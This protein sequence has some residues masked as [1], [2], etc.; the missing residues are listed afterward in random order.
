[1]F[2]RRLAST[3]TLIIAVPDV[4]VELA[5]NQVF[6]LSHLQSFSESSLD[7]LGRRFG[8]AARS[9][10]NHKELMFAFR[11]SEGAFSRLDGRRW[12][13]TDAGNATELSG[14]LINRLQTPWLDNPEGTEVT[15]HWADANDW[16][17]RNPTL[18]QK[19]RRP[20]YVV[21]KG[22]MARLFAFGKR[23][24]PGAIGWR[25]ALR[26]ARLLDNRVHSFDSIRLRRNGQAPGTGIRIGIKDNRSFLLIK[27]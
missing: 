26:M 18:S 10:R 9:F 2:S 3:G 27:V 22:L 13:R 5:Q 14:M 21:V 11:R 6:A 24:S 16:S 15:L 1:M 8:F 4:T 7:A 19:E 17:L 12:K 25:M 23:K 20:C